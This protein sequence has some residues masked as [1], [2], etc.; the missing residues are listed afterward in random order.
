MKLIMHIFIRPLRSPEKIVL[1]YLQCLEQF[2]V[3]GNNTNLQEDIGR[4]SLE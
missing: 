2:G 1:E 4:G 3:H